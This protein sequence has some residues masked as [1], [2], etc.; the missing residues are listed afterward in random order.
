MAS[1]LHHLLT[2]LSVTL[3]C[4]A[5][6]AVASAQVVTGELPR[7][8][9]EED[10]VVIAERF[11]ATLVPVRTTETL[12][13]GYRPQELVSEGVAVWLQVDD[14]P[15]L[16]TTFV[17]VARASLVEV[18]LGG[19]W[20]PATVEHGTAIF[21]LAQ[22]AVEHDPPSEVLVLPEPT[23]LAPELYGYAPVAPDTEGVAFPAYIGPPAATLPYYRTT[24][25]MVRNGYPIV[26]GDG[27]LHGLCSFV[28]ETAATLVVPFEMIPTWIEEWPNLSDS[29]WEPHVQT[30]TFELNAGQDAFQ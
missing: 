8:T 29:G 21:D 11:A 2:A 10:L 14:E 20:R 9:T 22:L 25:A 3:L 12:P 6:P 30:E 24:S 23:T 5:L 28:D 27:A 4:S 13:R 19:Q 18:Y 15:I 17:H 16:I 1:P 26:S 7:A